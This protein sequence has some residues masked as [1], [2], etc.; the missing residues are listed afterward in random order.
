MGGIG[1]GGRRTD[2][3]NGA[4]AALGI[5][6][7]AALAGGS[8][9]SWAEGAVAVGSTGDVV[10]DGIAFGMV[11]N[12]PKETAAETAVR[13]CRTFQARAA[14]DRCKVVATFSG[15]CFA[16]AYDPKPGTP[17][18]G[19]GV[20]PDQ[21]EA[22]RTAIAMCEETAGPARK[23]YCQVESGGCDTTLEQR[24]APQ[25][26]PQE[27]EKSAPPAKS[28]ASE[29]PRPAAPSTAA[30][31]EPLRPPERK[32][33]ERAREAP[34]GSWFATG[35]PLLVVGAMATVG[36]AYALGQLVKGKLQGGMGQAQLVVGGT[37]A[38]ASGVI[39]K[40]LDLAG[41]GQTAVAAITGL[42]ALAAAIFA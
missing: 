15:Q 5:A 17:G 24:D 1:H 37:L 6:A 42:V 23:G 16:V 29:R 36:A 38:I 14:A 20:G 26:T 21:L 33:A 3:R 2:M 19:W 30:A 9:R 40:L 31:V 13:R 10:R 35:S 32:A 28:G 22:N 34:S 7:L 25:S 4:M 27:T 8:P 18:A 11:V 39:V 12:E 41:S